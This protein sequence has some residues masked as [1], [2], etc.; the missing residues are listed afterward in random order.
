M[1]EQT[2]DY[3]AAAQWAEDHMTPEANSAHALHGEAAAAY[4]RA[5]L[6]RAG[7]GRPRLDPTE[8]VTG[9]SPRRQVRLPQTLS[10]NVDH[11]AAAQGRTA[12]EVMRDAIADYL[13]RN[14]AG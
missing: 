3:A 11:L 7:V 2:K 5:L 12:A 13:I 14:Q 6:E 10:D 9:R 4:G 1:S 8:D